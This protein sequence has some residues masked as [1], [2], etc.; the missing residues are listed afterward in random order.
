MPAA[1]PIA[2]HCA[3]ERTEAWASCVAEKQR[4]ATSTLAAS[5]TSSVRYG[6]PTAWPVGQVLPARV[7][8]G[9]MVLD[10][11][12]RTARPA[13]SNW[14]ARQDVVARQPVVAVHAARLADADLGR[15][16]R[17]ACACSYPGRGRPGTGRTRAPGG[18]RRSRPRSGTRI[19]GVDD[20]PS[21]SR[22][23]VEAGHDRRGHALDRRAWSLP[24]RRGR[25]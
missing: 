7:G 22:G 16:T 18:G 19:G 13:S 9:V 20:P 15:R 10:R 17:R 12:R 5:R 2:M 21:S 23:R 11:A 25:S 1:W 6:I 8:A 4:P 3:I 14:R 24:S